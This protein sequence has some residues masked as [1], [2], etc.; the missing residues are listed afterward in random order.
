MRKLANACIAFALAVFIAHY[1]LPGAYIP[2]AAA[3]CIAGGVF[4][5]RAGIWH[6]VRFP[7]V[8][9]A[10]A[11]GFACCYVQNETTIKNSEALSGRQM[12]VNAVATDFVSY[13]DGYASVYI[14]LEQPGVPRVA[15][16]LYD[17]DGNLPALSPGDKI[18]LPVRFKSALT[19]YG[20]ESD[21]YSARRVFAICIAAGDCRVTGEA[22]AL[23][24]PKYA[25]L[26][27]K[28]AV[29]EAFDAGTAPFM[30]ALLM[31]EKTDFYADG[32]RY[33]AM[34]V[35]GLIHVVAVSGLHV[36]FLVGFIQLVMGAT[37]RSS[38]LCLVLVW[39]FVVMTGA[40][41][42]TVRAGFMQSLL[43]FAPFFGREN[44]G[45]TSLSLPLAVILLL[46]PAEAGSAALQ[47]SFAAM[48]GIMAISPRIYA[49]LVPDGVRRASG[50]RRYVSGVISSSLGATV[51]TV[52]ILALRF[53]Y[54]P[55]L[56]VLTNLLCL[57][58]VTLCFCGGFIACALFALWS[59]LGVA[60]GAAVSL[61]V[62]YIAA[63]T[64]L[65][66]RVPYAAVYTANGPAAL[67]LIM[68]YAVF[69]VT[70]LGRKKG[71][72]YRWYFPAGISALALFAALIVTSEV[73]SSGAGY[74]TALDVGQGQSVAVMAGEGTVLVDC[75]GRSARGSAGEIAASYLLGCGRKNLDAL[76]LTHLH[77][78][79]ANG[80]VRLMQMMKV[81]TLILPQNTSDDDGLLPEIIAQAKKSGTEIRY[82]AQDEKYDAGGATLSLYA[83]QEAGT[84]NERCLSMTVS[85]GGLDMLIT[86]DMNRT[87]ERALLKTHELSGT[88]LIM[89][90]HHG[91]KNSA[92]NELL[93]ETGAATAIISVGYNSYGHPSDAAL[94]R[95]RT[96]GA[97]IYR[98]DLN[99]N[100][101]V[102]TS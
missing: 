79:H 41:P 18:S 31:G 19:R 70:W 74:F 48:A 80:A 54:V 24:F 97:A 43:L 50:L 11:V 88:E 94:T 96:A 98:T 56:G 72:R 14:K 16:R 52:P 13:G 33:I 57:W 7:L 46:N 91:S 51:F 30:K 3:A 63:V 44:D 17:Y 93:E 47:M 22:H 100:I 15:A 61:L 37:R 102:R 73:Y 40:G 49:R 45:A 65:I 81:K 23:Y 26:A 71:E 64:G 36:A 86:G 87:A 89:A 82:I 28:N 12:T 69:I 60:A 38:V 34:R 53:G 59:E 6:G 76:V 66:S 1:A 78:D 90:G 4:S 85:A 55:M 27:V 5:R 25:A 99:G 8:F 35:S 9:F 75:G 21:Y 39:F 68:T 10:A 77:A 32:G 84:E 29:G 20:E 58:A 92:S 42:S 67:W 2:A 83:P 62:R 101:T 95:L